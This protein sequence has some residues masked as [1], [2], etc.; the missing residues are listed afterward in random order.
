V[1]S[2]CYELLLFGGVFVEL[3][4]HQHHCEWLHICDFVA[5]ALLLVAPDACVHVVGTRE[6]ASPIVAPV[7]AA[8]IGLNFHA[9]S[10]GL[11]FDVRHFLVL[12]PKFGVWLATQ[13]PHG[14]HVKVATSGQVAVLWVE[15]GARNLKVFSFG[16]KDE[17]SPVRVVLQ[18]LGLLLRKRVAHQA[19]L[20]LDLREQVR[21]EILLEVL[22]S[23]RVILLDYVVEEL[24][25]LELGELAV[26]Q[27][28]LVVL[29]HVELRVLHLHAIVLAT[30]REHLALIRGA[31][32]R[33]LRAI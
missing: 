15:L 25:H 18:V 24:L 2:C 12:L 7:Y 4:V 11:P 28:V 21:R 3:R 19:V 29:V 32:V 9:L 23:H 13:V 22:H 5:A 17:N 8:H 20:G 26:I 31:V 16:L 33:K 14:G 10:V 1:A 30:V 6:Q 27:V